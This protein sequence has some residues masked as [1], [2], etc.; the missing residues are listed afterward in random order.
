MNVFYDLTSKLT[1]RGGHRYVWGDAEMRASD[2]SQTGPQESGQLKMH[3]GLAGLTFRTAQKFRGNFDFEA[4]SSNR[5]YFRTSLQ[6]LPKG[7][8]A[9]QLPG[10]ERRWR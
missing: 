9:R 10:A 8:D 3:V 7:A 5:N 6:E 1:L 2:L 4:S